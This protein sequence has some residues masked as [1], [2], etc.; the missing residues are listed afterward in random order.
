MVGFPPCASNF[1]SKNKLKSPA[2]INWVFLFVSN[3]SNSTNILFS[4]STNSFLVLALQINQL[5]YIVFLM[6]ISGSP[7][8]IGHWIV[9]LKII[10][11]QVYVQESLDV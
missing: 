2:M 11:S 9:H 6:I 1:E 7:V 10:N 8:Q 3:I 5:R 4:T